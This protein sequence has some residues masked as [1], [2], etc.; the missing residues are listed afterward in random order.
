MRSGRFVAAVLAACSAC[1]GMGDAWANRPLVTDTADTIPDGRCQFEPYAG[2]TRIG[3]SPS[4]RFW[5]L[6]L[7]C[8]VAAHTQLGANASRAWSDDGS[9]QAIGIGGKSA[10]IPLKDGATG[11]AVN[12]GLSGQKQ[13]GASWRAEGASAS[14]IATR[15]IAE[16]W[17][18]HANL[19]WARSRSAH[20]SSTTWAAATEYT[21]A[22]G[23]V[24]SGEL[25]GDDRS[26]P[27]TAAGVLWQLREGLSVNAS[28]GVQHDNPRMRQWTAGFL[29]EF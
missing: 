23:I 15:E 11:I 6:Q 4:E 18:L 1:L 2:G 24:L 16:G 29:I 10:L 27:W 28:Y 5:V 17:L 12:Y 19:G 7:N 20:Q 9:E 21:L 25:Y 3:G 14:L 8:G 13:R 26:R 22:P